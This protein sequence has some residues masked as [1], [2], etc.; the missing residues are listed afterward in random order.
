MIHYVYE[1]RAENGEFYFG[2][3][4][5]KVSFDQDRYMGSGVWCRKCRKEKIQI[6][7]RL[8]STHPTREDT[9]A[10]ELEII[11]EH[12]GDP[13]LMNQKRC[14]SVPVFGPRARKPFRFS[15]TQSEVWKSNYA[16]RILWITMVAMSDDTGL[17]WVHPGV[18]RKRYANITQAEFDSAIATMQ[19]WGAIEKVGECWA[20][21]SLE[22]LEYV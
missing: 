6:K 21:T 3:R 17:V 20:F 5:S 13:M 1:L 19:K 7:K 8:V 10:A 4:S 16:T 12:W 14:A 9:S 18:L 2:S 15:F 11:C 22:A